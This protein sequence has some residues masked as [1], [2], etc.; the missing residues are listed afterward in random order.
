MTL[1]REHAR[2]LEMAYETYARQWSMQLTSRLRLISTITLEKV[3][4]V[5]YDEYITG[6][7]QHTFLALLSLDE[8]RANSILQ[9]P[10][11][12]VMTWVDLIL[13]GPGLGHD[14]PQRDLTEIE[15]TLITDLL[16]STFADLK[17]AF[18]TVL[19]LKPE[20]KT[21]QYSPQFVQVTPANEAVLVARFDLT[22]NDSVTPMT[23]MVPAETLVAPMRLGESTDLQTPSEVA[24][25]KDVQDRLNRAMEQVPVELC[26]SFKPTTIASKDLSALKVGEVIDLNHPVSKP[27]ELRIGDLLVGHGMP[28]SVGKQLA[29][30][31]VSAEPDPVTWQDNL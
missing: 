10:T 17:Y 1:A 31:I 8:S 5:S 21:I 30:R 26:V 7:D 27:L 18:A 13:G 24:D 6:L 16:T 28:G 11:A 20:I 25:A 12:T 3:E 2:I 23:L 15:T 22:L 19:D 14:I 4:L 29:T 9:V